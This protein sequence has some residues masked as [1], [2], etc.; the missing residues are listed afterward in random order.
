MDTRHRRI[1]S[2]VL[3]QGRLTQ[4]QQQAL[5]LLWP[6]F[7]IDF[8][9]QKLELDQ[10]FRR[11]APLILEIGFG[12][13]ESLI[14]QA[15]DCPDNNYLGIEV[16]RPG[17]G[18]LLR[19]ASDAALTNIRVINHDAV[20]VLQQQIPDS[21]I[22]V[23]QLFFPDPWHKKRHHKRRI[24]NADFIGLIHQKLKPGGILH[25]ATDWEDYAEYMLATMEQAEGFSNDAGK[26]KYAKQAER[27]STR[28]EHR[29]RRLGHRVRDL[30]FRKNQ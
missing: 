25:L 29:G 28:F 23:V 21:S 27:P 12:N 9:Q 2:Y 6:E 19:L 1:K 3:R 11:K 20:E 22:D 5:V 8:S 14:E 16:H 10:V 18:H 24:V 26:G 13:G 15:R 7:G 30:V 17:V 4:G